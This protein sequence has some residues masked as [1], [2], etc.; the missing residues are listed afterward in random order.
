MAWMDGCMCARVCVHV[1]DQIN[2]VQMNE[3]MYGWMS[4]GMGRMDI[5]IDEWI[6]EC[7]DEWRDGYTDGCSGWLHGY[8]DAWMDA[9]MNDAHM[10]GYTY[11]CLY[12]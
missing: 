10:G 5:L 3:F 12:G 11:V 4:R 8:I 7:M 9:W 1:M 2:G 6:H